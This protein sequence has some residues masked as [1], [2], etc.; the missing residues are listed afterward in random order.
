MYVVTELRHRAYNLKQCGIS[1]RYWEVLWGSKG[2][3]EKPEYY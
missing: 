1:D 3:D 2:K